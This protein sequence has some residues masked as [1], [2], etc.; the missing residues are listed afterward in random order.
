M[1]SAKDYTA[2]PA[3]VYDAHEM[4]RAFSPLTG[5]GAWTLLTRLAL[6][7]GLAFTAGCLSSAGSAEQGHQA[8]PDFPTRDPRL[9]INSSPLSISDLKGR[10]VLLDV[11]TYG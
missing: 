4:R 11:W 3:A 8:I 2:I 5:A 7:C 9:W 6:T 10:V 1:S